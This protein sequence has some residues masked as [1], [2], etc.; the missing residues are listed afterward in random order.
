MTKSSSSD[1]VFSSRGP[2]LGILHEIVDYIERRDVM[3]VQFA[4][5]KLKEIHIYYGVLNLS[6]SQRVDNQFVSHSCNPLIIHL[7]NRET[8]QSVRYPDQS[9]SHPNAPVNQTFS[10]TSANNQAIDDTANILKA[11]ILDNRTNQLTNQS[12]GKLINQLTNQSVDNPTANFPIRT[13]HLTTKQPSC[14]S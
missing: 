5:G 1:R 8:S 2:R 9:A 10:Q 4:S 7:A 6:S 11:M 12:A 13:N 3:N 14:Q